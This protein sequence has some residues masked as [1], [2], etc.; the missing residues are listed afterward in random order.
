MQRSEYSLFP[1]SEELD[2]TL[3]GAFEQTDIV[4]VREQQ[5]PIV[6]LSQENQELKKQTIRMQEEMRKMTDRIAMVET[7]AARESRDQ[8]KVLE[9]HGDIIEYLSHSLEIMTTEMNDRKK[10]QREVWHH[11]LQQQ[12]QID[13]MQQ[14]L[15]FMNLEVYKLRQLQEQ[16]GEDKKRTKRN[17][18]LRS[19]PRDQVN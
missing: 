12:H 9:R 13:A 3:W 18:I 7:N 6:Q 19:P 10:E 11:F 5:C 2:E 8:Y 16:N 15:N 4:N 14:N 17:N 1:T